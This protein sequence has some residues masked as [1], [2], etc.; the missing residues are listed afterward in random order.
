MFER[1][2]QTALLQISYRMFTKKN[3]ANFPDLTA[4]VTPDVVENAADDF[5]RCHGPVSILCRTGTGTPA[6]L[7]DRV[8]P[9]QLGFGM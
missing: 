7:P 6:L 5:L 4:L 3:F 8:V 2:F 9:C 1:T